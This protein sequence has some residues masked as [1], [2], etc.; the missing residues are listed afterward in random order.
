MPLWVGS[1][2]E[3]KFSL[4]RVELGHG[5]GRVGSR[6]FDPCPSLSQCDLNDLSRTVT[7]ET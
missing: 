2:Y 6:N 1:G 3:M 5:S 7:Y 4:A